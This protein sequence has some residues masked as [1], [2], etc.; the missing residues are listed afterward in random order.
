MSIVG[1]LI[2]DQI[3]PLKQAVLEIDAELQCV[4]LTH[5]DVAT[6]V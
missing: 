2:A 1:S 5:T 6:A 4:A 3:R